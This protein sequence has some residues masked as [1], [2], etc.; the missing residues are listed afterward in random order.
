M[1]RATPT[2][3]SAVIDAYG[4]PLANEEI[5]ERESG[6]VDALLPVAAPPT[7]YSRIG[8]LGFWL[9]TAAGL[10]FAVP[11]RRVRERLMPVEG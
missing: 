4:R 3:V 6:F 8:D 10:C 2:G 5:G 9:L 1:V 11:W 7:L